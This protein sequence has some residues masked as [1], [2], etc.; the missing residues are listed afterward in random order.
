MNLEFRN[1]FITG[2]PGVGKTHLAQ[3]I[4]NNT[5]LE[6]DK[7]IPEYEMYK[8]ID[9]YKMHKCSEL[10]FLSRRA[11]LGEDLYYECIKVK[12]LVL[13]DLGMGE[14]SDYVPDIVYI[15]ID[16]RI[17]LG[18]PT[19]ITTNLSLEQISNSIDRR[20]ASRLS[21][22]EFIELQ[23]KDLRIEGNKQ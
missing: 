20:L 23:G 9:L 22:F 16:K 5:I 19:I 1:L 18:K 15:V 3:K 17:D 2:T 13:D 11:K 6:Y 8:G 12:G 14:R 7:T 21:S 10:M 4:M